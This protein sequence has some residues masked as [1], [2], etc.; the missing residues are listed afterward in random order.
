MTKSDREALKQAITEA[1][2]DNLGGWA[3]RV[4][5][6]A[7][8]RLEGRHSETAASDAAD[9]PAGDD[10]LEDEI[11]EGL[12]WLMRRRHTRLWAAGIAGGLV[13]AGWMANHYYHV[14]L[15]RLAHGVMW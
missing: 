10:T 15:D 9:A 11:D 5:R 1:I 6:L 3:D 4:M 13:L 14:V 8:T 2:D 7:E 12:L